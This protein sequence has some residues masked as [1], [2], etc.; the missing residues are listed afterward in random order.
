M[1][2]PVLGSFL[3]PALFPAMNPLLTGAIGSGIGSLLQ[4]D[5]LGDA[6]KTGLLSFA[7][8]KLLGV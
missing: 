2:L 4:G 8:G 3:G 7:G 6:I 1:V 5:D